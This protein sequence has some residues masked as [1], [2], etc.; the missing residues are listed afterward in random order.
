MQYRIMQYLFGPVKSRRLGISLGIDLF[1]EKICNFNCVYCEIGKTGLLQ[2][3]RANYS[4]IS[5][6]IA[7]LDIFLSERPILDYITISGSGEPTLHEGLGVLITHIK[8][9]YPDYKICVIT[10]STLLANEKVKNA[11]MK[12]DLLMPS[13]DAVS[14]KAFRK[15]NAPHRLLNINQ[16]VEGLIQFS[17]EYKG[18]IWLE[19]F[20]SPEVND[21]F[22]EI[23]R[24][25]QVILQINPDR[26]QLNSLDR[27][28]RVKNLKKMPFKKMLQIQEWMR[29]RGISNVE[30]IGR[31]PTEDTI[32]TNQRTKEPFKKDTLISSLKRRPQTKEELSEIF[33]ATE[34][35]IIEQ[36]KFLI[37]EGV[38]SSENRE[39]KI[40]YQYHDK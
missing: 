7:E 28:G 34:K 40:F 10:N 37:D 22:D 18:I 9:K 29:E 39:S 16:I 35:E 3:D 12:A 21:S 15:I 13:L 20:L 32:P 19:I 1:H 26:V 25:A 30:I 14:E 6:I 24:M 17:S 8:E 38:I 31:Y 27:P 33:N 5:K 2:N 36:L 23:E 4:D 11:L